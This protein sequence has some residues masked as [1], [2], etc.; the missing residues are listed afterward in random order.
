M[1]GSVVSVA[2]AWLEYTGGLNGKP[3]VRNMYEHRDSTRRRWKD[4]TERQIT[5]KGE[6]STKLFKPWQRI[7]RYQSPTLR[8]ALT[9]IVGIQSE[10]TC[11]AEAPGKDT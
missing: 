4:E 11:F 1:S 5:P 8:F 7:A 6:S 10:Q 2:E 3:S 9:R